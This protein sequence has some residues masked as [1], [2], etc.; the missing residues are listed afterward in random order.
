MIGLSEITETVDEYFFIKEDVQATRTL[1][2]STRLQ[3]N[4]RMS[5]D[6]EVIERSVYNVFMLLGDIGGFSGLLYSL[7]AS[8]LSIITFQ[9]PENYLASKLFKPQN[10]SFTD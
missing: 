5:H 1:S 6:T 9:N 3:M 10:L 4:F 8:I 7:G 2:Y